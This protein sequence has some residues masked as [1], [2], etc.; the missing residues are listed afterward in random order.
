MM[1]HHHVTHGSDAVSHLLEEIGRSKA[2]IENKV[3][4]VRAKIDMFDELKEQT[5]YQIKAQFD[6]AR[7]I[8][9]KKESEVVNE[10][11]TAFGDSLVKQKHFV[12]D[13]EAVV[14]AVN[15]LEKE[16]ETFLPLD[17]QMVINKF[18]RKLEAITEDSKRKCMELA[19]PVFIPDESAEGSLSQLTLGKIKTQVC[20]ETGM[21]T[22]RDLSYSGGIPDLDITP[23]TETFS[24]H[25]AEFDVQPSIFSSF[26][27]VNGRI[28]A[29]DKSNRKLKIFTEDGKFLYDMLF[30]N[31]E[32]YCV[33]VL[34]S[35]PKG[36]TYAITFPKNKYI[37]FVFLADSGETP[38]SVLSYIATDVGYSGVTRGPNNESMFATVVSNSGEPR[39]DHL[40]ILG[41]VVKSFTKDSYGHPMFSFPRYILVNANTIIVSDHV[42]NAVL[43]LNT[44]GLQRGQYTGF[45]DEV[46]RNPYGITVD[47]EGNVFVVNGLT[48]NIHV[49]DPKLRIINVIKCGAKLFNARLLEYD[50]KTNR[51]AIIHSGGYVSMYP[52]TSNS[53]IREF[54]VEETDDSPYGAASGAGRLTHAKKSPP[55]IRHSAGIEGLILPEGPDQRSPSPLGFR[56]GYCEFSH[57]V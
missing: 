8:L 6:A 56:D 34:D 40:T 15:N 39:V 26:I 17:D 49:F 24:L 45:S 47:G 48:N 4:T 38:P 57:V 5:I 55:S 33:A 3:S 52:V 44:F 36:D 32:P 7:A 13:S 41:Q 51:L 43:F 42:M 16:V 9:N 37:Y 25:R 53:T 21:G 50:T 11:Q 31:A 29:T 54:E 27:W 1:S 28:V 18:Y 12:K 14:D 20:F 10:A 46:L 35:T 22:F 23:E 2:D 30:S 19:E